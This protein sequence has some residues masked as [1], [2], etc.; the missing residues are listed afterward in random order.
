MRCLE[1]SDRAIGAFVAL[2]IGAAVFALV[3]LHGCTPAQHGASEQA[4]WPPQVSVESAQL[5]GT[6]ELDTPAGPVSVALESGFASGE[7]AGQVRK[8]EVAT[9]VVLLV[10]GAQQRTV[11][12]T[13]GQPA[14]EEWAQCAA[15]EA[16]VS[17]AGVAITLR[18]VPPWLHESCGPAQLELG[19]PFGNL[20][21]PTRNPSPPLE[22]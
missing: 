7:G 2:G 6:V 16:A 3:A 8:V 19:T 18:A 5:R 17:V 21:L 14:G 10:N 9:E 11:L 22:E 15:V 12:S 13:T 20:V 4:Q 1:L